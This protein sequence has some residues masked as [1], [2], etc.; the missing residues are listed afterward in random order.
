MSAVLKPTLRFGFLIDLHREIN[1]LCQEY[2]IIMQKVQVDVCYYISV[3]EVWTYNLL[4][5][6]T[7]LHF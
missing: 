2:F 1:V 3:Y 6:D 7:S 5:N 4:S